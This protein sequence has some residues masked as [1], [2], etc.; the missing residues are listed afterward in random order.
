MAEPKPLDSK[1]K[2][3]DEEAGAR[4]ISASDARGGDKVFRLS[5]RGNGGSSIFTHVGSLVGSRLSPGTYSP[6]A[7]FFEFFLENGI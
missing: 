5:R 7:M 2:Q 3:S 6:L 1:L 4:A